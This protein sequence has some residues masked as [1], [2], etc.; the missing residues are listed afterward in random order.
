[1]E[2][3]SRLTTRVSDTPLGRWRLSLYRPCGELLPHVETLWAVSGTTTYSVERILPRP[4]LELLVNLESEPHHVLK[5]ARNAGPFRRAWVAG[6]QDTAI[7][8]R[9]PRDT[10]MMGI[11][12]RPTGGFAF[13]GSPMA[14]LAGDVVE[15]DALL[16]A[17]PLRL[18]ERLWETPALEERFATLEA[19]VAHRIRRAAT[20]SAE[21]AGA[22]FAIRHSHG[23]ARISEV[24]RGVG[25][26]GRRLARLFREQVGLTPKR[27]AR[28]VRFQA[29]LA[30]LGSREAV[31]WATLA[32]DFGFF[33]QAHFVKEFRA[34]SR[35]WRRPSSCAGARPTGNPS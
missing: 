10:S 26:S 32:Q 13:F 12:F 21:V 35:A 19:Y 25:A 22:V 3:G 6:A 1:V 5:G 34:P 18:Q 9:S 33:D 30:E 7:T 14:E 28:V 4:G 2:P 20:P 24:A 23:T 27:F 8:V 29:V 15:L 17:S 16:G 31:P 11:R